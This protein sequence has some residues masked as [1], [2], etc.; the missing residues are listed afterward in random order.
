V[1]HEVFLGGAP[2]NLIAV[3]PSGEKE[4]YMHSNRSISVRH[5]IILGGAPADLTAVPPGGEKENYNM[6]I[7]QLVHAMRKP[8][9][10]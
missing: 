3:P 4:N 8:K 6:A 2:A 5:E 9:A 1:R 10:G 7:D